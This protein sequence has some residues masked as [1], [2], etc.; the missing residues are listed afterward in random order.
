MDQLGIFVL[1]GFVAQLLDGS[2]GMAYGVSATSFLLTFGIS[3]ALAS[4]T[5]HV[6]EIF[7]TLSSGL[8]HWKFGNVDKLLFT[9][10]LVPGVI[11]GI[12]GAYI[13]SNI[14]G[15]G[16]KPIISGYLVVMGIVIFR[17]SFQITRSYTPFSPTAISNLGFI[18]GFCDAIGGGG[19]GPVVTTNLVVRGNKTNQTI[20]S[21]NAA[22][23][24]V[25]L[26]ES[27]TFLLAMG[28][29]DNWTPIL[30]LIIGG[31]P[32]SLVGAK[33]CQVIPEKILMRAVGA[34]IIT[35]SLRTI[36]LTFA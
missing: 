35:I 26:A 31:V 4:A 8:S 13:L 32:A 36:V 5:T 11:G 12:S 7:T 28:W 2:L 6:S 19:W 27:V 9:R 23:F 15:E 10:L 17:K 18:G 20:G 16:I 22:E 24:F 25:T 30:G 29:V 21:V 3:P 33:L 1:V 14:S 34:L